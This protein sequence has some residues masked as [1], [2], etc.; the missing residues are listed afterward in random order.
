MRQE[1][2]EFETSLGYRVRSHASKDCANTEHQVLLLQQ[3][4]FHEEEAH[5]LGRSQCAVGT[6]G[7]LRS[8]GSWAVKDSIPSQCDQLHVTGY[9]SEGWH[10]P[11]PIMTVTHYWTFLLST[12]WVPGTELGLSGLAAS[13][14]IFWASSLVPRCQVLPNLHTW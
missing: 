6:S 3:T 4:F 2:H 12:M 13:T 8:W 1:H 7:L 14:F 10:P 11:Y 5:V 9:I